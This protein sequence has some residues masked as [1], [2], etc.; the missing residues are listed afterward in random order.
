M[1]NFR[2]LKQDFSSSI[3]QQG[4]ELSED[5]AVLGAKVVYLKA[6]TVRLSGSVRGKHDNATKPS[7]Q[8]PERFDYQSSHSCKPPSIRRT[9]SIRVTWLV[10]P[11]L[12][13]RQAGSHPSRIRTPSLRTPFT[14]RFLAHLNRCASPIRFFPA[15]VLGP[16]LP[17]PPCHPHRPL[18]P[19]PGTLALLRQSLPLAFL[20][21]QYFPSR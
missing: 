11:P 5:D 20:A 12:G 8:A 19:S 17:D 21:K 3:V 4:K 6:D 2:K 9:I 14:N 18:G 13:P 10:S 7:G 1:L 16:L 15:A